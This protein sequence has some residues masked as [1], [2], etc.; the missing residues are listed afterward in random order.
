MPSFKAPM[1]IEQKASIPINQ[2]ERTSDHL[3][4]Y[5]IYESPFGMFSKF[6]HCVYT[7]P[8]PTSF[9]KH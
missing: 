9:V 7:I 1:H 8:Y 5:A 2:K 6:V 4:V 3:A